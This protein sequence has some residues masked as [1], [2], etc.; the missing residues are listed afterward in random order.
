[1]GR[2][3]GLDGGPITKEKKQA[4]KHPGRRKRVRLQLRWK[5]CVKR[6]VRKAE[7]DDKWMEKAANRE[8]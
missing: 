6:D 3:H 5:D 4:M 2:S 8:K 1:M 7:E